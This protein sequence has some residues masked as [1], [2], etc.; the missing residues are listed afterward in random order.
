MEGVGVGGC[1]IVGGEG[2]DDVTWRG[3]AEI[4]AGFGLGRQAEESG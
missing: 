2:T 4:A 3:V 1:C